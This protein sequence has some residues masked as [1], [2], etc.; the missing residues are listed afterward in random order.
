MKKRP[1]S[2]WDRVSK[3]SRAP[4][5][6]GRTARKTV[7][8]L[9]KHL[10]KESVILDVGCGPG[11]LTM[12][13][14]QNVAFVHAIDTSPGMIEVATTRASKQRAGNVEYVQGNLSAVRPHEGGF[15]AFNVLHY[16]EDI[17]EAARKIGKL[18]APEELFL[19]STVCLGDRRSFLVALTL[20]LTKLRV[21]P[22]T[23]FFKQIELVEL[24][25]SG[26][27]Q[28]VAAKKLSSLPEYFIVARKTA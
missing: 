13:I 22:V 3:M 10:S 19:S 18:L 5:K 24:I 23:H 11:D 17:P 21:M 25:A 16:I 2:F 15:T 26:G 9:Q 8:A 1:Q 27:F 6:L 28:I 4:K 20:I 12:A 7:D 14:V